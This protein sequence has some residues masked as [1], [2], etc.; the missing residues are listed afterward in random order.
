MGFELHGVGAE[1]E[2]RILWTSSSPLQSF[3]NPLKFYLCHKNIIQLSP[4]AASD[5]QGFSTAKHTG[6]EP[7]SASFEHCL[8]CQ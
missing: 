1:N 3:F 7:S 2:I 4:F 5:A 8:L 6:F